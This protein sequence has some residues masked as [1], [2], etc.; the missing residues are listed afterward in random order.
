MVCAS[1]TGNREGLAG[2]NTERE[3]K[4][5]V[6]RYTRAMNARGICRGLGRNAR[7]D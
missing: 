7:A 6:V 5:G 2:T 3:E 4:A 1:I